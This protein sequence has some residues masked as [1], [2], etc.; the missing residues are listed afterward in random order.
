VDFWPVAG[1]PTWLG[2][3]AA[4]FR[5]ALKKRPNGGGSSSRCGVIRPPP[6]NARPVKTTC[7]GP[8]AGKIPGPW[9]RRVGPSPA[10]AAAWAPPAPTPGT[11]PTVIA[12]AISPAWP[13]GCAGASPP[14][15]KTAWERPNTPVGPT[16]AAI[17]GDVPRCRRSAKGVPAVVR[18]TWTAPS[19][20]RPTSACRRS[21]WETP[22]S[23]CR[24]LVV[25][26]ARRSACWPAWNKGVSE[27]RGSAPENSAIGDVGVGSPTIGVARA[28]PARCARWW[29]GGA[30]CGEARCGALDYCAPS[31]VC[32]ALRAESA[33][34]GATL[35]CASGL[36]CLGRPA[37]C[38]A[39]PGLSCP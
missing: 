14:W 25:P 2:N 10:A 38:L 5:S 24:W 7:N 32:A 4:N 6:L 1:R 22:A 30:P 31:G 11:A 27:R 12:T 26:I 37:R 20:R 8:L 36:A 19:T 18:T 34:C 3:T 23:W 9:G 28:G 15:M 17:K 33:T 21:G 39:D 29:P 13:V 16:A 35:E